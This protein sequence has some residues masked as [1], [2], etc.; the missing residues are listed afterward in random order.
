MLQAGDEFGRTQRGNNN[1]Y[2]Q[3]GE[4][5]WVDWRLRAANHDLLEFA[6]LLAQLR[7]RHVGFRRE[8][9]L[10]GT[11][12]RVGA[13]DV[14]WLNVRGTEMTQSE[15]QDANQRTLGI[16]FGERH[17]GAVEHLL[18]LVNAA[19]SEQSFVLPAA[20]AD[21]PWICL[22]DTASESLAVNSLG[23]VKNYALKA[24]SVALLEC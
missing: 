23:K 17:P 11:A 6:R 16:W 22:F 12:S 1:A 24:R 5:S 19:D 15:W 7:R 13:R 10:K 2:C 20:P 4:I 8:T 18:L 14:T 9:F 21:G 3:D